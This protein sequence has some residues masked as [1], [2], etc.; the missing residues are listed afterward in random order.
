MC[1]IYPMHN[2]F[3]GRTKHVFE[4]WTDTKLLPPSKLELLQERLDRLQ[5]TSD[6]GRLPGKVE[7]G[8]GGW[9][10]AQ[11]KNF[12]I[13]YS[14]YAIDTVL[15][16]EHV[17]C[18]QHFVKACRYFCQPCI[19]NTDLNIADRKLVDFLKCFLRLYRKEHLTINMHLHLHIKEV[20]LNFLHF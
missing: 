16:A 12:T 11:W 3:L 10:A 19:T 20:V 5:A 18:W 13:Y 2:L 6:L 1:S 17:K 9:T 15:P 14:L 4:T 8:F 7:S